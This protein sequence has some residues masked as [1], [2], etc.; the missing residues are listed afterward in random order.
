MPAV[1]VLATTASI[2]PNVDETSTGV[3]DCSASRTEIVVYTCVIFVETYTNNR[4]TM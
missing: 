1:S 2:P 4:I 3:G